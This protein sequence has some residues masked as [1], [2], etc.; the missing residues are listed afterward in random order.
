[1]RPKR[2]YSNLHA[3]HFRKHR[4][5]QGAKHGAKQAAN[6]GSKDSI[7][8]DE[9]QSRLRKQSLPEKEKLAQEDRQVRLQLIRLS[10]INGSSRLECSQTQDVNSMV[11]S[12]R[13]FSYTFPSQ[14]STSGKQ[15]QEQEQDVESKHEQDADS[16]CS[17]V[18]FLLSPKTAEATAAAEKGID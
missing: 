6:R 13:V 4:A 5:K 12:P 16:V 18:E 11:T 17:P 15:E 2:P 10:L 7:S 8:E 9:L 3:D 14:P 1:M